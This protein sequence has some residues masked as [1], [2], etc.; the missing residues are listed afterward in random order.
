M[1]VR[2]QQVAGSQA[3]RR[4]L[5]E[6]L[7]RLDELSRRRRFGGAFSDAGI[8]Q[9]AQ[10]WTPLVGF[11]LRDDHGRWR[12]VVEVVSLGDGSVVLGLSIEKGCRGQGWGRRLMEAASE[13][14]LRNGV[15]RIRVVMT[16]HNPE[17]S[18]L[19]KAAGAQSW[20]RDGCGGVV[21]SWD[22]V[23]I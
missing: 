6:H 11:A 2:V 16:T 17:M 13:W 5:Q 21:A 22:L 12:G 23:G 7:L 14:A 15:V 18:A 10:G 9:Y 3:S 19:A 4:A 8:V 1:Q 20:D